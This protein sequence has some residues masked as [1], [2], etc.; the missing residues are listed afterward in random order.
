MMKYLLL[1]LLFLPFTRSFAQL[2]DTTLEEYA[3]RFAPEK[4]YLHLDKSSYLPGETIWFKAY[5][6]EDIFP[7]ERSKTIYVDWIGNDGTVLSH[8][9]S[10]IVDGSSNGQLQIPEDYKGD[11]IHVRAYTKWMLNFDTAFLYNRDVR[12]INKSAASASRFTPQVSLQIFP[13]GGDLIEGIMNR[14]AFKANDQ[15]GRPVKIRGIVMSDHEAFLDSLRVIHDGM[16]F[17]YLQPQAGTNYSIKWKNE[18]GIEQT[19]KI[20]A[21]RASGISMQLGINKTKRIITL[22]SS[23]STSTSL[24]SL[25]LVGTMNGRKAFQTDIQL[26]ENSTVQRLIPTESLPSGIL[27]FTVFDANW[28]AVAERISFIDNHEYSF[29]T[30]MEVLHWGLGK[31]KRNEIEIQVPDSL[32]GANLSIAVTDLAIE[33]DTSENIISQFL[34]SS[35]LK[36]KINNPAYYF[37]GPEE[38]RMNHLDLV[39]MTNGWRRFKWE[40]LTKGILPKIIYPRDTAY[41]SLSGQVFGVAKSVLSGNETIAMFIKEKDSNSKMTFMQVDKLG[42][43][44]DPSLVFFDTLQVYYSLKSK[45]FSQAEARF[46][47]DRLPTPDYSG[48][49]KY[50]IPGKT[51]SDTTGIAYH[52]RQMSELSMLEEIKKTKVLET[53]VIKAKQ[54]TPLQLLDEKYATGL[55]TSDNSYQFDMINNKISGAYLNILTYLQGRVAG[56]QVSSSTPPTLTWR[57]GAPQIYLDEFQTDVAM[58]SNIPVSDI[59]YVKVFRPPFQGGFGGGGNGAIAVY[60]K[61]GDDARSS[62]TGLSSNTVYGYTPIREFYSPNYD[63]FDKRHDEKDLRT[64]LYWNPLVTIAPGKNSIKLSFFNNDVSGAFRI[65]IEG[66]SRNGLLTHLEQVME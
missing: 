51:I 10:P 12:V 5:V 59:A 21:A 47:P 6:M 44:G 52:A 15:W 26:K 34:L 23:P 19:I 62:G 31:R 16:G 64:T 41:L 30:N 17:F 58:I 28:N 61:K 1:C 49:S 32:Q 50:F 36:G 38:K 2:D 54:K 43:F 7:A 27:V 11:F 53:I 24:Q 25:H 45:A 46:M 66:M 37:S 29:Q 20:P 3:N 22:H 55:F 57:G 9:V 8:S 65:V 4:A 18:K 60:T 48:F 56:L 42:K 40:D 63:R 13:E 39:M 33:K 14:I 35:E